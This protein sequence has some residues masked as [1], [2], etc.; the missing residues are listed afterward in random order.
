ML[1]RDK[2]DRHANIY[3]ASTKHRLGDLSS[4]LKKIYHQDPVKGS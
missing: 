2:I 4:V 1:T 3:L